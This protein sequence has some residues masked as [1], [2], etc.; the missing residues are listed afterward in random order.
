MV[1]SI[2]YLETDIVIRWPH[3]DPDSSDWIAPRFPAELPV[4]GHLARTSGTW[5]DLIG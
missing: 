1:N 4:I 3:R 2:S 5:D